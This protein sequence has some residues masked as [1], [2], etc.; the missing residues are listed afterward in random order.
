MKILHTSDWHLGGSLFGRKRDEEHILFLDWLIK[1]IEK[2]KIDVLLVCGDIFDSSLPSNRAQEMYYNFLCQ[3]NS[4]NCHN[5]VI[6]GGNHDSPSLLNAPS[7]L[8]K[9]LNIYIIGSKTDSIEEEVILLKDR[10]KE[11]QAV[12]C[13]VPFLR[14]RD[15]RLMEFG[16]SLQDKE[17]KLV[18]GVTNH[19]QQVFE[20]AF[21]M[22]NG[23]PV[24]AMG[25][26]FV[27]GAILQEGEA[28]RELYM[29]NLGHIPGDIF[30]AELDYVALGHLHRQQ[31]VANR[32]NVRYSGSPIPLSFKEAETEKSVLVVELDNPVIQVKAV[33]IPSQIRLIQIQGDWDTISSELIQLRDENQECW[34]DINYTGNDIRT[35]L[36]EDILSLCKGY[37]LQ[38]L[39]LQ[40][41]QVIKRVLARQNLEET[42]DSL[43]PQEVFRRCLEQNKIGEPL[44]EELW[45]C[46]NEA[47]QVLSEKDINAE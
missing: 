27:S 31:E 17:Q 15:L 38:I 46:Y 5:V 40:N 29:G 30:P 43:N 8:L 47:L 21:R 44:A 20:C 45:Q 33:E 11:P 1:L 4:T 25:H 19:Y 23:L 13:A 24:I 6:I 16:E 36:K 42:L 9:Y 35:N 10:N 39:R 2:E 37:N 28:V 41:E 14:E 18:A 7:K 22:A 26:L 32:V 3:V 12:I 34:L